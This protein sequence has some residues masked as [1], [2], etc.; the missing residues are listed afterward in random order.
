MTKE[1]FENIYRRHYAQMY[2]LARVMLYDPQESKDVVSEVFTRLLH[3]KH[4]LF[5]Y[6]HLPYRQLQGEE[7]ERGRYFPNGILK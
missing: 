1:E 3:A 6:R 4:E 7:K 2:R 5:P